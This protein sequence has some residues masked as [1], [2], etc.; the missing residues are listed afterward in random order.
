MSGELPRKPEFLVPVKA[1]PTFGPWLKID[2]PEGAD[3]LVLCT[4]GSR[5][6]K[7]LRVL[8]PHQVH[9]REVHELLAEDEA[10]MVIPIRSQEYV[11][12]AQREPRP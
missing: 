11:K 5:G 10:V 2:M 9:T 3:V 4:V 8:L 7:P 1:D 6:I 12:V